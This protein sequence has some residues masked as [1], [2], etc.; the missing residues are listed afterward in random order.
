MNG[1]QTINMMSKHIN[2]SLTYYANL[3]PMLSGSETVSSITSITPEDGALTV[4]SSSVLSASTTVTETSVDDNGTE[5][6]VTKT[7]AAN[8]GISLKLSGGTTG[9]GCK[10]ITVV[11]MKSTGETD[12]VDL[13]ITV[14]GVDV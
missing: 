14:K 3:L 11:F 10:V 8:K 4:V 7:I 9:A 5:T 1:V 13:L 12:S 2:S 6:T